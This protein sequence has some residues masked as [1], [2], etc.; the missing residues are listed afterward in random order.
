MNLNLCEQA[1]R[2]LSLMDRNCFS[3]TRGSF[4]RDYWLHKTRDF[5]SAARQQ[6]M[7]ALSHYYLNKETEYFKSNQILTYIEWSIEYTGKIQN[8]DG[9][10]DEWYPNERGWAGPT[11]YIIHTCCRTYKLLENDLNKDSLTTLRNII[12]KGA[13]HL[14]KSDELQVITNHIAIA[15][16]ALFESYQITKKTSFK[17]HYTVLRKKILDNFQDEGWCLEYDGP[18]I[19]YQ[20]AT[21]SFLTHVLA[22][23]SDSELEYLINKSFDFISHFIAPSGEIL[24]SV[25][26]RNTTNHFYFGYAHWSKLG[27][28]TAK[29][30]YSLSILGKSPLPQ[31][32]EDHYFLYRLPELLEALYIDKPLENVDHKLACEIADAN[33]NEFKKSGIMTLNTA[34]KYIVMNLRKGGTLS[35]FD[36]NT[37]LISNDNGLLLKRGSNSFCTNLISHNH[38]FSFKSSTTFNCSGN[39]IKVPTQYFNPLKLILFRLALLLVAFNRKTAYWFKNAIKGI[40]IT[41]KKHIDISFERIIHI[42]DDKIEVKNIIAGD[43]KKEDTLFYDSD[44]YTRYVPQSNYY[45]PSNINTD[46][47]QKIE[48]D[49]HKF[50]FTYEI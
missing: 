18:D 50:E 17:N 19:G 44:F 15:A 35:V 32:N 46:N 36:K 45:I 2:L 1:K 7:L 22:E 25:S 42:S 37:E 41:P 48:S 24:N 3:E 28:I 34:D 14:T 31:H 26:S 27:N 49:L 38:K 6:G 47:S 20:S 13:I 10:F 8:S 23:E 29:K 33:E 12:E 43:L 5:S 30:L 21:I 39:F 11:A 40:L 9:S 4:D 16:T